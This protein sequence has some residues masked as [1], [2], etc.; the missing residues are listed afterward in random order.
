MNFSAWPYTQQQLAAATHTWQLPE[1][2]E[3][4]TVNL[5]YKQMGVG[6]DTS[7]SPRARPLEPYQLRAEPYEYSIRIRPFDNDS[8]P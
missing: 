2:P 7:W 5:D 4:F 8:T 3:F 6:G 1:E